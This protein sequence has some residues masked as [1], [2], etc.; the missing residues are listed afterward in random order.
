L[1]ILQCQVCGRLNDRTGPCH[2]CDTEIGKS[3]RLPSERS[4]GLIGLPYTGKTYFL[5]ALHDQLM[6]ASP[7]WRVRVSD[8]AFDVL[9]DN[10]LKMCSRGA[11]PKTELEGPDEGLFSIDI[12]W[13]DHPITLLMQDLAGEHTR[14]MADLDDLRI[15]QCYDGD[16][17]GN[18]QYPVQPALLLRHMAQCPSLMVAIGCWDMRDSASDDPEVCGKAFNPNRDA[19]MALGRLFRNLF[20]L[21]AS[22]SQVTAVLVGIDLYGNDPDLAVHSATRQFEDAY[23]VFPGVV[24]NEGVSFNVVPVSNIGL[25]NEMKKTAEHGGWYVAAA[26]KPYNVLE[27]LRLALPHYLPAEVV[28][29]YPELSD[30]GPIQEAMKTTAANTHT[31]VIRTNDAT[32][33]AF[34]SYRRKTGAETARLIRQ[35]LQ[36]RGWHCFIDVEDLAGSFFDD[37]LMLEI[38]RSEVLIVILTPGSL[39]NCRDTDDWLRREVSQALKWGKLVV[40]IAKDGFSFENEPELPE[41]MAGLTRHNYVEYSHQYFDATIDRLMTF[42]SSDT[43]PGAAAVVQPTATA[44]VHPDEPIRWK[45]KCGKPL[46]APR[47]AIG[48]SGKCPVCGRRNNVPNES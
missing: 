1:D 11:P 4:L 6:H 13:K 39:Q 40:P 37:R 7:D 29:K 43:T 10:F 8:R 25:S 27:P 46:K 38:K 19:D 22:V 15:R 35:S 21:D 34:L 26:P 42:L 3:A 2:F 12:L 18:E 20:K 47:K 31:S 48:K 17:D 14:N 28:A 16:D 30:P 33:K 36:S 41:D 32:K 24:K 23:R 44:S 9:T 45:C 5:A